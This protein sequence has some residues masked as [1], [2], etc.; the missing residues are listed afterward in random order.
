MLVCYGHNSNY[1][2]TIIPSQIHIPTQIKM[3]NWKLKILKHNELS[4]FLLFPFM[5]PQPLWPSL[6]DTERILLGS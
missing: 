3:Q 1:I 2:Y 5:K 6:T 4:M